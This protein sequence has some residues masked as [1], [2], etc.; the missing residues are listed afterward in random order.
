MMIQLRT[1]A[2]LAK[3][4]PLKARPI[5]LNDSAFSLTQLKWLREAPQDSYLT[6][7]QV[8]LETGVSFRWKKIYCDL[9]K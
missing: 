4:Y 5:R 3:T 9:A 1:L 2:A 7:A 6:E 8:P